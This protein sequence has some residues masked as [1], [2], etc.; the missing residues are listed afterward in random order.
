MSGGVRSSVREV[1]RA[2]GRGANRRGQIREGERGVG[3]KG[4]DEAEQYRDG[5]KSRAQSVRSI[6]RSQRGSG[7]G[8]E[9]SP[10]REQ[11]R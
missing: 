7:E 1:R 8:P 3:K 5:E 11:Q 4:E 9:S 2:S 10:K 6:V